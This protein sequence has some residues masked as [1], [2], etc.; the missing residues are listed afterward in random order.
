MK[1]LKGLINS[2]FW[3]LKITLCEEERK[4]K[5]KRQAF[6][7]IACI[8]IIGLIVPSYG[9]TKSDISKSQNIGA[10]NNEKVLKKPVITKEKALELGKQ[11]LKEYFN[12]T[13]NDQD[14]KLQI[15]NRRDWND[16]GRYVWAMNWNYDDVAEYASAYIVID[17]STGELLEINK[18]QGQYS[19]Q[20]QKT[21][22]LTKEEAQ[23]KAEVFIEKVLP[24]K[25]K[26]TKLNYEEDHYATMG[27]PYP[28]VYNFRY[29]RLY[30]DI[31]YEGNYIGIG[32]D[33]ATGEIRN[34]HY[35]WDTIKGLPKSEGIK[36]LDEIMRIYRNN[37][38][39]ELVYLPIRDETKPYF[40]L[41]DIKLAYKPSLSYNMLDA[42][43]GSPI[44]K[45][46]GKIQTKQLTKDQIQ[47]IKKQAKPVPK[48]DKEITREKAKTLANAVLKDEFGGEIK[49]NEINYAEGDYWET[50]D[51]KAWN[52]I[53]EIKKGDSDKKTLNGQLM[54]DA[55]TEEIISLNQ[56]GNMEP[57][58][59]KVKPKIT[60]EEAYDKAIAW[61][62]KY[63]PGKIDQ[64]KLQQTKPE[65]A[66]L[67]PDGNQF[68]TTEYYFY[69]PRNINGVLYEDNQINIAFN[70]RTGELNFNCRW[71]DDLKLPPK[72]KVISK[73]K[74]KDVTFRYNDAELAYNK[75]NTSNDPQNPKMEIK[76]VYQLAPKQSQA[77]PYMLIDA[78]SAKPIDHEG[79]EL[80]LESNS[81]FE[82]NIKGHWIEKEARILAQQGILDKSSF[83]PNRN[84]TKIEAIKMF[85]ESRG[86]GYHYPR[87]EKD[88]AGGG[89]D[90]AVQEEKVEFT[91]ITE[92]SEDYSYVQKAI[93]YGIIEN[94]RE[95]L[96]KE[97][98]ISRE[99]LVVMLV[100]T[101]EYDTLAQAK[102]IFQ[103]FFT[104][105]D[106]IEEE[107]IGHI[108]ICEGL[109]I[110]NGGTV[111]FRP[112]DKATMAEAADMVYK[113]LKYL[114]RY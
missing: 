25:L 61:I 20:R 88:M 98:T 11:A 81:Q 72:E 90:Q 43:T 46:E 33:G 63:H 102:Q 107:F 104:D 109:S 55:L 44:N 5:I 77:T 73:E 39:M 12:M 66:E 57:Y 14:Y 111:E 100:K 53:F 22:K 28:I 85:V 75:I 42:K 93:R 82:K 71:S 74:A 79:K 10:S 69:F 51:R 56:W 27:S 110:I 108:A 38:D 54:I 26:E 13:V 15:E 37:M 68:Y 92:D 65:M 34:F 52:V 7:L 45:K 1:N 96:K 105:K 19:E 36:T 23:A 83:E 9:E 84:I 40:K 95:P 2:T 60:W 59:P 48:H 35:R 16:T 112:K 29:V 67:G 8:L 31:R 76:L 101:L 91:D 89:A 78:L 114:N 87:M 62:A 58:D 47:A 99:E 4:M 18:D 113:S 50:A 97:E 103:L 41:R 24:G 3:S 30:N 21:T 17:S 64:L 94:S 106:K 86:A 70:A 80:K 6:F 49:I 32:I